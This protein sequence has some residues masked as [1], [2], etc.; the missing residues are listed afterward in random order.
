MDSDDDG[1]SDTE[2]FINH[3]N[4]DE[5]EPSYHMTDHQ[6]LQQQQQQKQP[7]DGEKTESPDDDNP[8]IVNP[9]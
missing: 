7:E 8:G 5:N 2:G 3:K 1:D 9:I 6:Q 4:I